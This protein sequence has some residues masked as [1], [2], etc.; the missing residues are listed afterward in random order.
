MSNPFPSPPIR[1]VSGQS[2]AVEALLLPL[3]EGKSPGRGRRVP[4]WDLPRAVVPP[5][6]QPL[7]EA[8]RLEEGGQEGPP[9]VLGILA[10]DRFLQSL[11][12]L[13]AARFYEEDGVFPLGEV[14][15]PVSD[16]S[17]AACLL[18]LDADG[19]A[20]ELEGAVRGRE[21]LRR[22]LFLSLTRPLAGDLALFHLL[23]RSAPSGQAGDWLRRHSPL[24]VAEGEEGESAGISAGVLTEDPLLAPALSWRLVHR[25]LEGPR[26]MARLGEVLAEILNHGVEQG[27]R[28]ETASR[29]YQGMVSLLAAGDR[30]KLPALASA[31]RAG[32]RAV[33]ARGREG[34]G[35]EL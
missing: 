10:G 15:I 30:E 2:A 20:P 12:R 9:F 19:G 31:V 11:V 34:R 28:A 18:R 21:A 26:G 35:G 3:V 6:G 5:P 13:A 7:G 23:A 27:N 33:V 29:A 25:A 16:A 1:D 32:A 24:T 4:L 22:V 8:A 14:K 17:L